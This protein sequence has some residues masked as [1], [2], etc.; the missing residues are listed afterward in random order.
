LNAE[1]ISFEQFE[2]ELTADIHEVYSTRLTN[3]L[4]AYLR[5]GGPLQPL[6]VE[7]PAAA[8]SSSFCGEWISSPEDLSKLEESRF[9]PGPQYIKSLDQRRHRR[10]EP[11]MAAFRAQ[12]FTFPQSLFLVT[13]LDD[14]S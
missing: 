14:L 2:G 13:F 5:L 9:I 6:Y 1:D 7:I 12:N 11:A 4:S 8:I 3:L 10:D